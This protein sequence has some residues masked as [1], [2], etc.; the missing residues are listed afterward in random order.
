MITLYGAPHSLYTGRARSYL[1]KAGLPYRETAAISQHY[2]TH[3]KPNA[4]GRHGLPTVEL[5]DGNVIRDGAAIIDHFEAQNGHAFSPKTP[6]QHLF[7]LLLDVIGAEGLLRPAMHYRWNFDAENLP[8]L[9]LHFEMLVPDRP[10]RSALALKVENQMRGAAQAFGVTPERY[11]LI[12]ALYL[13]VLKALDAH[14]ED[15]AYLLGGRPC[16]GDFGMLAPLFA[17]LGRDPKP[18]ALMQTEAPRVYRWVERMNRADPDLLEYAGMDDAYLPNDD[19][20]DSLLAALNVL[21]EDFV[22]ETLAAAA[23]I[24]SWLADQA[25][26][27][28]GSECLR[29]VGFASFEVR[30]DPISALAQPYRFYLLARV[31]DAFE[32]MDETDQTETRRL[33]E[34]IQMADLLDAR[35]DR[36]IGRANNL[37]VWL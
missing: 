31:Q 4:G 35:L 20:P 7:S 24:N 34:Q 14:F 5:A 6:K 8:F 16:I 2:G 18:L 9:R 12:E 13:D 27:A 30:G 23:C 10:D 21:A 36:K 32:A 17:H 33:L 26:L 15:H 29:G 37:E 28:P 25:D 3:V 22:P 19:I 1:I 11:A